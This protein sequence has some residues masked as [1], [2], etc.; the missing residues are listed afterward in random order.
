LFLL[1]NKRLIPYLLHKL[2]FN[3]QPPEL[4]T[5]VIETHVLMHGYAFQASPVFP[6]LLVTELDSIFYRLLLELAFP[7]NGNFPGLMTD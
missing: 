1:R 2:Y 7:G 6:V 4:S 5:C 3:L